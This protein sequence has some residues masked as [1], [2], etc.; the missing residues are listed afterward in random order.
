MATD[1]QRSLVKTQVIA[2]MWH[3][4]FQ[5]M[6]DQRHEGVPRTSQ[7]GRKLPLPQLTWGNAVMMQCINLGFGDMLVRTNLF[8]PAA[9]SPAYSVPHNIID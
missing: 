7:Q 6:K 5:S 1:K 3:T 8:W 2:F 4:V 9:Q